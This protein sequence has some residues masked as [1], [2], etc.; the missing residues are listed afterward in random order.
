MAGIQPGDLIAFAKTFLG[1][2]YVWGG[3]STSG[4]DCSGFMYL[5]ARHF[6]ISIPRGSRDQIRLGSSV[7]GL[8][9]A[10]AGDLIGFDSMG[11]GTAEHIGMYLGNNQIIVADH[12]GTYVRIVD[13][14]TEAPIVGIVRLPGVVNLNGQPP[15]PPAPNGLS[16]LSHPTAGTTAVAAIPAAHPTFDWW[17]GIGLKSPTLASADETYGLIDTFIRTNPELANLYSAAVAGNWSQDMFVAQLQQTDWWKGNSDSAR[18]FLALKTT[19][20]AS[21]NQQVAAKQINIQELA[22]KLGVH[23]TPGGL[24][25]M[26]QTAI[27]LNQNDAQL[28]NQL[29]NYL[30]LSQQGWYGGYAGQVELGLKAYAQDQGIPLDDKYIQ[31]AVTNIVKGTDTLQA[32]RAFIQTQAAAAFPAYKSLIDQGI[33]VGQIAMPYLSTMSK[34]WEQDPNSIDLFNSTLR[35]A[36]QA[37]DIKGEPV[38]RQLYDFETSL[39]KDPTWLKT[40]NAREGLMTAAKSVMSDMGFT[41]SDLGAKNATA[42]RPLTFLDHSTAVSGLSGQTNFPTLQ[43]KEALSNPQAPTL[44]TAAN[45]SPA[46]NLASD[47]SFTVPTTPAGF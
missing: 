26:A 8:S 6:G 43:G 28:R 39:R 30:T 46:A 20:P 22:N 42:P 33:T 1:V 10:Q 29:A 37:K 14:H 17:A 21:Y 13:I 41:S 9:Q 15:T 18:K 23:L 2:P 31:N 44:D 25:N 7:G 40:N 36:L 35:G 4:V 11:D 38:I 19:D 27:I 45:V 3:T 5:I 34:L 16:S 24:A 47:N 12:T 32:H